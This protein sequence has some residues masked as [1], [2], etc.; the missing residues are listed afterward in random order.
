MENR[1]EG[2]TVVVTGGN[3]GIGQ[4]TA[5]AFAQE[6]ARVI[7][8][9]RRRDAL[10]ETERLHP[11]IVG[12]V[13]DVQSARDAQRVVDKAVEVGGAL[14]ILVN[15]AGVAAFEPVTS[16]NPE[17]SQELFSI[18]VLGLI[19]FTSAALPALTASKG[20]IVNISSVVGSHT[21]A[22]ASVYSATK[23]AV[24]SLTRTWAVELAPVG[25]RVNA[26][27]PGPV[28]TPIFYKG[29]IP[30]DQIAATKEH[31][32]AGVPVGRLGTPDDVAQ[33]VLHVADPRAAWFTGQ[34]VGI[35]GGKGA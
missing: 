11:S 17:T 29:G 7:V 23:A 32:A 34:V 27:A 8:T 20:S 2:K 10:D 22:G 4:A 25:V 1:F 18:N 35:D 16:L 19:T 13:A 5:V 30:A 33:W 9:G 12:V 24:N 26:V 14:D 3:S 31:L 6:G 21:F 15:N 28:E